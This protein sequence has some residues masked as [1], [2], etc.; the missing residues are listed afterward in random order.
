MPE[1][2]ILF[3][4][5]HFLSGQTNPNVWHSLVNRLQQRDWKV[6]TASDKISRPARLWDMLWTIYSKRNFYTIAEIDVFSGPSFIW[7]KLSADLLKLCG[8]L[9]VLT[10]HGGRLPEFAVKHPLMVRKLLRRANE[11]VAPS[12]YLQQVL[13]SYRPDI[14]VIPNPIDIDMYPSPAKFTGKH[15]LI[16]VRAFHEIYNPSLAPKVINRLLKDWPDIHLTMVGP[17]KGDGSLQKMIEIAKDLGVMDHIHLP[18]GVPGE[19]VPEY[20]SKGDFF[21][22]TTNFDNTPVSVIEAMAC[23]LPIVTTNVGGIPYLVE[24]GMDGLLVPPDDPD[25]MAE[26]LRK[27]LSDRNMAAKLSQNARR[28]AEGFDWSIV[29]PLWEQVFTDLLPE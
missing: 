17:D 6:I 21:I 5:N 20:L 16:W 12:P 27:I 1:E 26:A 7:A 19:K 10:L 2:T 3:I 28:K 18:G 11:V 22:N 13:S 29:L 14:V 8:K 4:G 23:G 9:F 25:A 15:N 24:D